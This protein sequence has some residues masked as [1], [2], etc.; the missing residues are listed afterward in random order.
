V[1]SEEIPKAG[2]F[3]HGVEYRRPGLPEK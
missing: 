3:R 2:L 1:Y